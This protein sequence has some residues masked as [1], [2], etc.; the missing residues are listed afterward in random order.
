MEEG[1]KNDTENVHVLL[2]EEMRKK[3]VSTGY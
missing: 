2:G 1:R 3:K